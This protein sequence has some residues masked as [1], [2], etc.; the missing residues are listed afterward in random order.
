MRPRASTGVQPA[1]A[2]AA[3]AAATPSAVAGVSPNR[4]GHPAAGGKWWW[5]L[6]GDQPPSRVTCPPSSRDS[7]ASGT[8]PPSTTLDAAAQGGEA[9][10]HADGA[11][12]GHRQQGLAEIGPFPAEDDQRA[13]ALQQVGDGVDGGNRV[14]PPAQL[15]AGHV[16]RRQEQE[17]EEQ[18]E[19]GVHRRRVAGLEGDGVAE[20]CE[21]QAPQPREDDEGHDAE[22]PG[23][24][25]H[26]QDE[27]QDDD[28]HG[29]GA[30][31]SH[32]G[33]EVPEQ[34]GQ[35]ADGREQQPVEVAVLHVED[36]G[37]GPGHPGY[38]QQDRRGHLERR[39]VEARDVVFGEVGQRAD[40]HH[41]EE[42]GDE[43]R[44]DHRFHVA[45]HGSQRPT[46]DGGDVVGEPGRAGSDGARL[47]RRL[48]GG[49]DSSHGFASAVS[50]SVISAN[51]SSMDSSVWMCVPVSSRNTSSSVG[52][53]SVRSRTGMPQLLR[54]TATGP[55]AG[56][57]R[58][59]VTTSSLPGGSPPATPATASTMGQAPEASPSSRAK[60]T[61]LPMRRFSSKGVP[62]ATSLPSLIM[63][64]WSASSSASSRYW[65]VRKMVMSSSRLSRRTSS[66]TRARLTGSSPVVGSSRNSTSGLWTRAAARSRRRFMPPE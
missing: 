44:R 47:D 57:P 27:A 53:R 31:H 36:Q 38:A 9:H 55:M 6:G 17:R 63:P 1:S 16:R 5:P 15:I 58:A 43:D 34:D 51:S 28:R 52:V 18:Q 61:S 21:G 3:R 35:P 59:A 29:Q 8:S 45:G 7:Q 30:R 32:V 62:S 37:V 54:A 23:L 48:Q 64:T 13:Q 65:V 2:G 40:V 46:G 42:Q 20:A 60:I 33:A 66:H 25:P 14:E 19:A 10:P 22:R 50:L 41:E 26:P 39:E 56:G 12:G 4:Q 49:V 24:E 11:D